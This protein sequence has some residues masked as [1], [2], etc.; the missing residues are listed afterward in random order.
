MQEP[1]EPDNRDAASAATPAELRPAPNAQCTQTE[2]SAFG[3]T[4]IWSHST[5]TT[6]P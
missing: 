2:N 3:N 1:E 5:I 6:T 4:D